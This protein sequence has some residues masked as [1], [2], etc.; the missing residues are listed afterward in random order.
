MKQFRRLVADDNKTRPKARLSW[1]HPD[2]TVSLPEHNFCQVLFSA[3]CLLSD[4]VS[5][6]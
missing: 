1:Y 3:N 6:F 5:T 2:D 4:D